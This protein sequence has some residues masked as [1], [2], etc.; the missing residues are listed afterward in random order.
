[1]MIYIY[2]YIRGAEHKL[3]I[4]RAIFIPEVYARV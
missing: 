3:S 4:A 1:M 2:I